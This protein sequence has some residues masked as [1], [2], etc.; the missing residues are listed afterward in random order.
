GWDAARLRRARGRWPGARRAAGVGRRTRSPPDRAAGP[1][2]PP[3]RGRGGGGER[4]SCG[5]LTRLAVPDRLPGIVDAHAHLQH[6]VFAHDLEAVLDR[7]RAAG[8]SRIL[9]PGWDRAS[10]EA[11]LELASRHSDLLDAAVGIH[12]HYVAAATSADW[13]A[14]E[15]MVADPAARAV[16]EIG[17]DFYR[18][19]S[20]PA[21]QRDALARQLNLAARVRKPVIVHDR[22]AHADVTAA[23]MDHASRATGVPGILHA[24]SGDVEMATALAAVGYFISF[25]LPVTF[26]A[27]RGPRAAAATL[28]ANS[29]LIETDSP[30]LGVAREGRN[31]P[32]T[33]LRT[34]AV[35][36]RLRIEA[37]ED[38]AAAVIATY[39]R[40]AP[41][42]S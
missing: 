35:I 22:E 42:S 26:R 4:G 28:A 36:A 33:V 38:V 31:E 40:L 5:A 9:V 2:L 17:L 1:A 7:A 13:E 14:I 10:S 19:F 32:T 27:N 6:E 34:A 18:N 20:P 12:P 25:A 3:R 39:H 8:I 24:F 37:P 21:V 16:G 41:D 11:A 15:L 30:Y 29:L 23:L